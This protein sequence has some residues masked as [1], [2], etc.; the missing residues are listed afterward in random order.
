MQNH[1]I[2]IRRVAAAAG[3]ALSVVSISIATGFTQLGSVL[4]P[5][6]R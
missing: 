2:R 6:Y 1:T 5:W 3:L 4:G